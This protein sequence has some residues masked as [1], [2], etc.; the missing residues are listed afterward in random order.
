MQISNLLDRC[1][2]R[3]ADQ[4]LFFSLWYITHSDT[5]RYLIGSSLAREDYMYYDE[6]LQPCSLQLPG[7]R[8]TCWRLFGRHATALVCGNCNWSQLS[9]NKVYYI[10]KELIMLDMYAAS[11]HLVNVG[12]DSEHAETWLKHILFQVHNNRLQV[13]MMFSSTIHTDWLWLLKG[14]KEM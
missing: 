5:V 2:A 3:L 14:L 13:C 11:T 6:M 12:P 4:V 10:K 7:A 1:W 8:H 9:I